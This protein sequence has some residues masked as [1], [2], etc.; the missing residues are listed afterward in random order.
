M[1]APQDQIDSQIRMC[2]ESLKTLHTKVDKG[3][4]PTFNM[5]TGK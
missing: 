2:R 3:L 5:Y 4:V 1:D